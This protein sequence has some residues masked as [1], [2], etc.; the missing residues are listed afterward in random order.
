MGRQ[1][2]DKHMRNTPTQE[3]KLNNTEEKKC[4][5][6]ILN[7]PLPIGAFRTNAKN[8]KLIFKLKIPTG[9]RQTSC[10]FTSEAEKLNSGLPRT[11]SAGSQN[12][13]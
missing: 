10:I 1:F 4:K 13:I 2:Q 6:D 11:T 9:G 5:K 3:D 8:D 12:G 7:V